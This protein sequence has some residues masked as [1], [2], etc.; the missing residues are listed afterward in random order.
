MKNGYNIFWTQNALNE[1]QRTIAYLEE[2]FSDK[3]I[4]RLVQKTE[5]IITPLPHP[6]ASVYLP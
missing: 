4:K 5:S 2:H 3:E 6:T 1:L